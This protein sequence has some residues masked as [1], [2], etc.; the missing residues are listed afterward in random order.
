[1]T[2]LDRRVNEI[3]NVLAWFDED[4]GRAATDE[5]FLG[6][7]V[8][9]RWQQSTESRITIPDVSWRLKYTLKKKRNLAITTEGEFYA[10]L[11][12]S[13]ALAFS[14]ALAP[15]TVG[16]LPGEPAQRARG[17]STTSLRASASWTKAA[18]RFRRKAA[19]PPAMTTFCP[20]RSPVRRRST[21]PFSG[22]VASTKT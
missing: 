4:F 6:T 8:V 13:G 15:R 3:A 11:G 12:H 21:L 22:L 20:A 16:E 17:V 9:Y 14:G 18:G 5:F 1:M 10:I 7:Y 2:N 19:V